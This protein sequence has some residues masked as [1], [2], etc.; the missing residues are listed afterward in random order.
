MFLKKVM[1]MV[2]EVSLKGLKSPDHEPETGE[3]VVGTLPDDL[4]KLYV[5]MLNAKEKT[6]AVHDRLEKEI[7]ALGDKVPE[8]K[9]KAI[10]QEHAVVHLEENL[11]H[12][13]FWTS[14]RLEFPETSSDDVG[15]RK[16]W[17]VVLIDPKIKAK[18]ALSELL[19]HIF[20]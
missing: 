3:K 10:I 1:G 5:V 4:K 2:S 15:L 18:K 9:K 19:E 11:I 14:V 13:L 20:S 8:E 12:E 17:Q 7:P 16:D 6:K